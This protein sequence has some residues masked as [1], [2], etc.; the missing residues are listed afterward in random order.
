[1]RV[2]R[3]H[4]EKLRIHSI[5]E[6]ALTALLERLPLRRDPR[7]VAPALLAYPHTQIILHIHHLL[8]FM[9]LLPEGAA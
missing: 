5:I 4:D 7:K 1:M 9:T 6:G 8:A 2:S 3:S